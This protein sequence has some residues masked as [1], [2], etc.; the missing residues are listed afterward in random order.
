MS[1]YDHL[2]LDD[3]SLNQKCFIISVVCVSL[4][5]KK[6]KILL[7]S[8]GNTDKYIFCFFGTRHF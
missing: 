7:A 1:I 2:I 3:T 4:S 5:E 6:K 8:V